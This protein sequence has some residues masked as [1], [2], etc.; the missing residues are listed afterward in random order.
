MP[1]GAHRLLLS[2]SAMRRALVGA[3]VGEADHLLTQAGD[4]LIVQDGRLILAEQSTF[5]TGEA[6]VP[7]FTIS[8]ILTQSGDVLITQSGDAI[9]AEQFVNPEDVG[10]NFILSQSLDTLTTQDDQKILA[11]QSELT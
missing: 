7:A 8:E 3:G 11:N 4:V 1:L 10:I 2:I 5:D 9:I 6:E